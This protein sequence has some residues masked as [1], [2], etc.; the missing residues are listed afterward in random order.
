[1]SPEPG[2]LTLTGVLDLMPQQLASSATQWHDQL[3]RV[4]PA[5]YSKAA[6]DL[7][8]AGTNTASP[9]RPAGH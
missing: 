9:C 5:E 8:P 2:S 7:L 4:V 6:L 3:C 1:V